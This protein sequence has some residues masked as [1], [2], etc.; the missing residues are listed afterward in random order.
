MII[1]VYS[2]KL[3]EAFNTCGWRRLPSAGNNRR[4]LK[5]LS[6]SHLVIRAHR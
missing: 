6:V 5:R 2:N 1:I 4:L 3:D